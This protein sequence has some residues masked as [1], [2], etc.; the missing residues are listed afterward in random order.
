[1][2]TGVVAAGVVAQ[3]EEVVKSKGFE[4][5]FNR[6][7]KSWTVKWD[8]LAIPNLRNKVAEYRIKGVSA[9]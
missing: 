3:A 7:D 5:V 1:M 6:L 9:S 4:A 8:W 2:A